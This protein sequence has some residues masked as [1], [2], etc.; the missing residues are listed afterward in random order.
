MVNGEDG[1]NGGIGSNGGQSPKCC[2]DGCDGCDETT[3]SCGS[4]GG[5]GSGGGSGGGILLRSFYAEVTGSLSAKGGNGG[6]GGDGGEGVSC[7][8]DAGLF[9]GSD[10]TLTSGNA[11]PGGIGGAGGGGRIKIF[12]DNCSFSNI[13][14]TVNVSGGSSSGTA[15]SGTYF[16]N[17]DNVSAEEFSIE[18]LFAF[19]PNPV[20]DEL[21]ISSKYNQVNLF[22][23]EL[24]NSNGVQIYS[25]TCKSGLTKIDFKELPTGMYL[26]RIEFNNNLFIKK[27]IK[28]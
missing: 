10:Q 3:L 2:S 21:N 25:E 22:N 26:I 20:S 24:V 11:S 27:I 13:A 9:C 7:V 15:E 6:V 4:G 1:L 8:Y 23:V 12:V 16:Y 17:C 14:P 18:N 5:G 19:Y 28:N